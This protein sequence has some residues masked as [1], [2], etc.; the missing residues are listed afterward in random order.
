MHEDLAATC[1]S[2]LYT[3]EYLTTAGTDQEATAAHGG[4]SLND[5]QADNASE[6]AD[7]PGLG[8][9]SGGDEEGAELLPQ[10]AQLPL[11][12]RGRVAAGS[13]KGEGTEEE[14]EEENDG[15]DGD[16]E[17]GDELPGWG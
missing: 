4:K 2:T 11:V 16:E 1:Q 10:G 9:G 17:A 12:S 3:L 5:A 13:D 8:G 6:D 15:S 14:E 7:E